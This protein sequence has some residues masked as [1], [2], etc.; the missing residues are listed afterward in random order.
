M[1]L[2][3]IL[4]IGFAVMLGVILMALSVI[5][6]IAPDTSI[7]PGPQIPKKFASQIKAL[8]LLDEGEEIRYFYSDGFMDIE[9]GLY[10]VTDRKLVVYSSLWNEPETIVPFDEIDELDVVYNESFWEDSLVSVTTFSE[11]EINFPLSSEK[12]LDR[13]F[14]EFIEK[15]IDSEDQRPLGRVVSRS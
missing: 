5:G 15:K 6:T 7:Y 3:K 2:L 11:M 8:N 13:K 4:A 14:V 10:F 9:T 1:K 12:G